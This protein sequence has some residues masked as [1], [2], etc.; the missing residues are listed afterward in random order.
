MATPT[1]P[2]IAAT[3]AEATVPFIPVTVRLTTSMT[4]TEPIPKQAINALNL[5]SNLQPFY[6]LKTGTRISKIKATTLLRKA[7]KN[8]FHSK[9]TAATQA[10]AI[11]IMPMLPEDST[12]FQCFS[13][14]LLIVDAR[15]KFF[16]SYRQ[17]LSKTLKPALVAAD[18]MFNW[19]VKDVYLAVGKPAGNSTAKKPVG[20]AF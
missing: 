2:A 16:S 11:P 1:M 7:P 18:G 4:V 14:K 6:R 13:L 19:L 10:T 20:R 8:G 17:Y 3:I 5:S 9:R 12:I 15:V